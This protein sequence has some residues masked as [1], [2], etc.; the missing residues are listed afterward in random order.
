ML[1][2]SSDSLACCRDCVIGRGW[3]VIISLESGK[4][5]E[6]KKKR[7]KKEKKKK[8]KNGERVEIDDDV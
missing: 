1:S 3:I 8:R 6:K 4:T 2:I 7:K 5:M